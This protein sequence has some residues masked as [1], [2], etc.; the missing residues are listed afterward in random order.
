MYFCLR[1]LVYLLVLKLRIPSTMTAT[2]DHHNSKVF[3]YCEVRICWPQPTEVSE[4]ISWSQFL[5]SSVRFL[6]DV[7]ISKQFRQTTQ[8]VMNVTG[9]S[10]QSIQISV[11]TN[12]MKV[13]VVLSFHFIL[14]PQWMLNKLW[15]YLQRLVT[16]MV[17]T[18][19]QG[20]IHLTNE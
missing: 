16:V 2:R 14:D 17:R 15:S 1:P 3:P 4:C 13:T 6:R 10:G 8:L 9:V 19:Q 7:M 20:K 11:C 18:H 12:C 5:T